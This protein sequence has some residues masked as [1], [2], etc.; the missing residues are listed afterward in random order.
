MGSIPTCN[1]PGKCRAGT[2]G[3]APGSGAQTEHGNPGHWQCCILAQGEDS[4]GLLR[5]TTTCA[6]GAQNLPAQNEQKFLF[7][8]KKKKIT[9]TEHTVLFVKF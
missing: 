8:Q 2:A 3:C 6:A 4:A 7:C 9:D 5:G 1:S